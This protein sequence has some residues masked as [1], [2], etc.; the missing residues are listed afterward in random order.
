MSLPRLFEQAITHSGEH[1]K[2]FAIGGEPDET[3]NSGSKWY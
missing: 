2:G 3:G 1:A